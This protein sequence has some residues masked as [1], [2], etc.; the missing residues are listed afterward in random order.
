M[1]ES[2]EAAGGGRAPRSG[3]QARKGHLQHAQNSFSPVC[4]GKAPGLA[5]RGR[6]IFESLQYKL[7]APPSLWSALSG[8]ERRNR[9]AMA[10]QQG[11]M[12]HKLIFDVEGYVNKWFIGGT[13]HV[14]ST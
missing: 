13:A 2:G 11:R 6:C 3:G 5:R 7:L 10:Q 12:Q 9:T 14:S 1:S 4:R 8:R